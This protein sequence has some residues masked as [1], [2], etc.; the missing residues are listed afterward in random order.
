MSSSPQAEGELISKDEKTIAV[1]DWAFSKGLKLNPKVEYPVIFPPGYDGMRTKEDI[2][3]GE[4]ILSAPNELMFST[5][6]MNCPE[7]EPLYKSHPNFFSLPDKGHEDYRMITYF[8]Y[9]QSKYQNSFWYSY[10]NFLPKDVETIIDWSDA[11]LS[12]LQDEDFEYDSKFRRDRDF[13]GNRELSEVL[14]THPDLF[15]LSLLTVEN[16]NW[17]WKVLCTRSYGRCIPYNSLIPIADLFNHSNVNTNYYYAPEDQKSPDFDND[18]L[19][20]DFDDTDDPLNE[21]TKVLIM[22]SMKLLRLGLPAA[23]D[24]PEEFKGKYA[25][26]L[27]QARVEDSQSFVKSKNYIE[28]NYATKQA[29]YGS[30]PEEPDYR[31]KISCSKFET[32]KAGSQVFIPYGKYSNRQLLT[33]YGFVLENNHYNYARILIPLG[34]FLN[35]IQLSQLSGGFSPTL[36][37]VFKLK[38]HELAGDL[39][40]VFRALNWNIHVH[41]SA[42]Y[43]NPM[44]FDLEILA[45]D[46]MIEALNKIVRSFPT[47]IEEDEEILKNSHGKMYFAVWDI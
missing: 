32:I 25:E 9:E 19:V 23:K 18:E 34:D 26:I 6:L 35:P 4:D 28:I 44:E 16:L 43:L 7:L 37:T 15:D 41:S 17:I 24:I 8:V 12:E 46:K 38:H 47:N 42:G 1:F 2:I 40:K 27:Q 3:P 39:L 22:A 30:V 5:K 20:V 14:K 33:N 10:L 45:L 36:P 11:D 31:F 13:K 29:E 21:R